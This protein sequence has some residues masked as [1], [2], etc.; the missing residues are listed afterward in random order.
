[1][2]FT[3]AI[4]ACLSKF[5][6]SSGRASRSEYWWFYL[7]T[8]VVSWGLAFVSPSLLLSLVVNLFF[9]FPLFAAGCRRLHDTNRSGWWQL[10]Y[11]TIIGAI[12]VIVWMSSKG[13]EQANQFGAPRQ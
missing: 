2:T 13:D 11:I 7:F 9:S 6:D 10:L 12:P 1:M 4:Q 8:A 5:F 3:D